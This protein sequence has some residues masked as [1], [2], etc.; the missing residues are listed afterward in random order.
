MADSLLCV[1]A[2]ILNVILRRPVNCCKHCLRILITMLVLQ[3]FC[4]HGVKAEFRN[5][6]YQLD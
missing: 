2:K 3:I 5:Y 6:Y 4:Q 1:P